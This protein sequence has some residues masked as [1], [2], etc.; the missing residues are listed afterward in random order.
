MRLNEPV[1]SKLIDTGRK[2]MIV[3]ETRF[4]DDSVQLRGKITNRAG[5]D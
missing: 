5:E 2:I 1:S 4:I 3:F